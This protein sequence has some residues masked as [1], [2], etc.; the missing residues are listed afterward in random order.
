MTDKKHLTLSFG[1][2]IGENGYE[3]RVRNTEIFAQNIEDYSVAIIGYTEEPAMYT[4]RT[5]TEK[6]RIDV[7]GDGYPELEL[8]EILGR[9]VDSVTNIEASGSKD[10]VLYLDLEDDTTTHETLEN[11]LEIVLQRDGVRVDADTLPPN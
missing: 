1:R 2:T 7:N 6:S 3:Y 9:V 10:F 8:S 11:P 4:M 5:M